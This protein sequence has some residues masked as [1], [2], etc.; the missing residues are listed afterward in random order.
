M[1]TTG[2]VVVA[3][4]AAIA[5][6]VPG[7]VMITAT[8]RRTTSAASSGSRSIWLSAQRY[9]IVRF[10]PSMWPVSFRPW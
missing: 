4:L 6:A 2:I 9:R 1:K 3:A 10:S 7:L 5:G 8:P